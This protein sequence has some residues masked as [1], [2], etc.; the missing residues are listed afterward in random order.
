MT[1]STIIVEEVYGNGLGDPHGPE[2]ALRRYVEAKTE[3]AREA[4]RERWR[5]AL[6]HVAIRN[7]AYDP[8]ACASCEDEQQERKAE[9]WSSSVR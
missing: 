1:A 7:H 9:R 6:W 8:A 2:G 5:D 3:A 4:E